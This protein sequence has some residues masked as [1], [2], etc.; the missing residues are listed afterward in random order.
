MVC[1]KSEL[2]PSLIRQGNR[3]SAA[4]YNGSVRNRM[5]EG[6]SST[7]PPRWS[8]GHWKC[9]QPPKGDRRV[10]VQR[11]T[12]QLERREATQ[13]RFKRHLPLQTGQRRSQAIVR[14]IAEPNVP[15]LL[16]C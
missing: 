1:A 14:T 5:N 10:P 16:T 12:G 2:A 4:V 11:R 15:R 9:P 7:V 8:E 6:F 3:C 13:H